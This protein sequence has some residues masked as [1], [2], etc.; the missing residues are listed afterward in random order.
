MGRSYKLLSSGGTLAGRDAGPFLPLASG[1][2]AS[3]A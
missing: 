1:L 3:M 2:A